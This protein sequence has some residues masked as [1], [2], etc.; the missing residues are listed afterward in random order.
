M[1]AALLTKPGA[2]LTVED[3]DVPRVSE[4]EILI[5]NTMCGVCRTDLHIV[6]GELSSPNLPLIPSHQIVGEVVEN[7]S[8]SGQLAPG[9]RVGVPWLG[10]T[11]GQCEYCLSSQENL[12]DAAQFTGYDRNGGFAQ[13]SV[14][15]SRFCF[16][17]QSELPI[18]SWHPCFVQE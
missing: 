6:D 7:K 16:P 12:C 8:E 4:G 9:Q 13:Y 15:D 11:C 5:R 2:P 3:V 18:L 14:V 1:L 10:W 17:L